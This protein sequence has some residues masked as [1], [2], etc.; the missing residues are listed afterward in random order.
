[1]KIVF[2]LLLFCSMALGALSAEPEAFHAL[3]AREWDYAMKESPTSASLLG[4]RRWNDRWPDLSVEA[5]SRRAGHARELLGNLDSIDRAKLGAKDQVSYDLLRFET[6]LAIDEFASRLWTMPVNQRDGIQLADDLAD[7]LRFETLQ[8]YHDWIARLRALPVQIDQTIALLR[9]G[10]AEK[11]TH[12][13]QVMEPVPGQIRKQ[14]VA[15]PEESPFYAPFIKWPA[16]LGETERERLAAEARK[17]IAEEVVPAYQRFG[18]FFERDYL[19]ACTETVGAWQWPGG[20]ALYAFAARKFTTTS[21]TPREIHELGLRE[22]ERITAGMDRIIAQVGWKG[23]RLEFFQHLREDKRFYCNTPEELLEAYR[24]TAKRID[25][26]LL[27]VFK[28]LPRT[29]YGVE[30]IPANVAPNTTAAYYRPLAADGSRA[31]TFFV[32]LYRPRMRP[33][34]EM[35]ALAM[36]EAVPG[37]HLQFAIAFEQGSLPNFRRYDWPSP[38]ANSANPRSSCAT[39]ASAMG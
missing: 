39:C 35:M 10:M 26:T 4:D 1:M 37:H 29:P 9:I 30:P 17:A 19:P 3:L 24:A 14:L 28:T 8:D 11:R 7:A 31:G 38:H 5:I 25:P 36:H 13:R 15:K 22:V 20:D 34:Y 2:R 18:E 23:S 32:N 6:T 16:A 21:M 12:A 27:K 33:R